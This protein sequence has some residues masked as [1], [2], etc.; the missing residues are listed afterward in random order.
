MSRVRKRN[1]NS[2]GLSVLANLFPEWLDYGART[3]PKVDA[4]RANRTRW[5]NPEIPTIAIPILNYS[6]P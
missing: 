6:K 1:E 3:R 5:P 2:P 4:L